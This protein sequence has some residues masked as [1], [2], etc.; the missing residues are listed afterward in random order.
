MT[1]NHYQPPS[2]SP[3][4]SGHCHDGEESDVSSS[5]SER[6]ER[7]NKRK[8]RNLPCLEPTCSRQFMNEHTREKHMQTHREKPRRS[9]PCTM[10]CSEQF[11]RQ[12]DRFRHEVAKHGYQSEWTCEECHGFFSSEKSRS[13][14]KC[15]KG[16][17][18]KISVPKYVISTSRFCPGRRCS[19]CPFSGLDLELSLSSSHMSLRES[20][21][22]TIVSR[23]FCSFSSRPPYPT[24]IHGDGTKANKYVLYSL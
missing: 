6:Q 16:G 20:D 9:F 2:T 8:R 19:S 3:S 10:G 5:P 7:G 11:S 15:V 22:Y 14:H 23:S 1:L 21:M 24:A 4:S 18:W 12:H 17:R 13:S